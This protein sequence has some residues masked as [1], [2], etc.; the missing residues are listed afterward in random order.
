MPVVLVLM[1][2]ET[3]VVKIQRSKVKTL[4]TGELEAAK[5][6]RKLCTDLVKEKE[7]KEVLLFA[8]RML[9]CWQN[10][11]SHT[12][13]KY[14]D[15]R[16]VLTTYNIGERLFNIAGHAV[17]QMRR[18]TPLA[19]SESLPFPACQCRTLI[20]HGCLQL[21]AA[22]DTPKSTVLHGFA[23]NLQ[24]V[25]FPNPLPALS[26]LPGV[27]RQFSTLHVYTH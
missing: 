3:R 10:D 23:F 27:C 20:H 18:G 7:S 19:N 16:S 6:Q 26:T 17:G 21:V 8:E 4:T 2:L 12:H 14:N 9:K 15:I 1:Q 25:K 11:P 5:H 13:S 22:T 24:E